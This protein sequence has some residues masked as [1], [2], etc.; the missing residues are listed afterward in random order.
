MAKILSFYKYI[1]WFAIIVVMIF[2]GFILYL[3]I[4]EKDILVQIAQQ[5][6]VV[7]EWVEILESCE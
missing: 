1:V 3:Q 2:L 4:I 5:S 6:C 7:L